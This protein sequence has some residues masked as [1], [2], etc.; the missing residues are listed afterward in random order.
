MTIIVPTET[1]R[2]TAETMEVP[3]DIFFRI[4]EI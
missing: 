4:S 3:A 1:A 2:K